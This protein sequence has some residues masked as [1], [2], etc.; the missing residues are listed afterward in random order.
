MMLWKM[1][2]GGREQIKDF[3]ALAKIQSLV[4]L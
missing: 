4:S 3:F 2:E 1:R